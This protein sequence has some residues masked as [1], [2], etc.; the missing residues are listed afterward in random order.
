MRK[1]V[2]ARDAVASVL[3]F[4][5]LPPQLYASAILAFARC[6]LGRSASLSLSL[7]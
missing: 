3:Y 5:D 1:L 6:A 7:P 4:E 2:I